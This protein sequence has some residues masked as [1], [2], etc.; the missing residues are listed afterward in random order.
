MGATQEVRD[1]G[2]TEGTSY[3]GHQLHQSSALGRAPRCLNTSPNSCNPSSQLVRKWLQELAGALTSLLLPVG[4]EI[5]TDE[6]V[7]R[8]SSAAQTSVTTLFCS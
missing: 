7:Q 1:F 5:P 6:L 2:G 8:P 3:G 4:P